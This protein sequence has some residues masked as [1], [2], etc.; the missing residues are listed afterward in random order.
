ME[1]KPAHV[2]QFGVNR[3]FRRREQQKLF[4]GHNWHDKNAAAV[5]AGA[6]TKVAE[7]KSTTTAN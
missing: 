7:R 5:A 3:F 2:G 4:M 1:G 6:R